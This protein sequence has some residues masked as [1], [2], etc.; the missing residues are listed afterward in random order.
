VLALAGAMLLLPRHDE[1][2]RSRA[3]VDRRLVASVASLGGYVPALLVFS[4]RST[5]FLLASA[6]AVMA[7]AGVA[8]VVRSRVALGAAWSL[9]PRADQRM[10][11]VTTG[12]Y[13][14]VRHPIYLG[15]TLFA[16]GEALAF[17]SWP[18]LL[19]VLG[20]LLP[21]F[22]WRAR[23]EEALLGRTFDERH[24]AYRRRTRMII[25]GRMR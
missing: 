7:L 6:G 12:P 21:S 17:A 16:A 13:R 15:F 20:G 18:A 2:A 5:G 25:P 1:S 9:V 19:V 3:R 4:C 24:A 14:L 11:L 8:L 10:G 22:V 23:A